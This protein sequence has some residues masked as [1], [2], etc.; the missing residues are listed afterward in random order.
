MQQHSRSRTVVTPRQGWAGRSPRAALLKGTAAVL[1]IVFAISFLQGNWPVLLLCVGGGIGLWGVYDVRRRQRT[2]VSVLAEVDA[3]S[4][5]T[6]LDY[7][8]DLLR[9]Q[10]YLVQPAAPAEEG[11]G[12]LFLTRGKETVFCRLW[13]QSEQA[14]AEVLTE[15]LATTKA[16]SCA[17]TM[18]LATGSFSSWARTVA[19]RE[20]CVLIDCDA[21]ATLVSQYR[22][23]HRVLA[24]R[25][26]EPLRARRRK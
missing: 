21:L 9:A 24:F 4:D 16:Y 14:G 1:L 23:G 5:E 10:G 12:A 22:Q 18:V 19:A 3:M 6:F 13:R 17:H 8:A 15:A 20:G 2:R 7:V 26:E 25:R 11:G